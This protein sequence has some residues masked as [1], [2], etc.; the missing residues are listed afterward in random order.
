LSTGLDVRQTL[1]AIRAF[2]AGISPAPSPQEIVVDGGPGR[3]GEPAAVINVGN[4]GTGI[5]L[6]AG[7]AAALDGLTVLCGDDSIARRP[8][9][10]VA[11]PLRQMGAHVDGRQGGRFPPLTIRGGRLTGIDYSPPVASAQVKGAV[12]LAGLGAEG[13]TIVR[14]ATPTRQHT[15]E[16]LRLC[17]AD[18]EVRPGAVTVR[19]SSL[20]PFEL[21]IPG[22]P[23]QA[24]FWVVA[25]CITPGSELTVDHVYV[26][27]GRAGFLDVLRRMG[28]TVDV[29]DEQPGTLTASITA[30]YGP[31]RGTVVGGA[32]VPSLI[33]E[34]PVLAVAAAH[35]EGTT[36]FADAGEL[37]VKESDR[38]TSMVAALTAVG[39]DAEARPDGL[40]VHGRGGGPD[41]GVGGGTVDSMGDHRVAMALAIAG[42]AARSP[43]HIAGWEAVLTSYPGFEEDYR[44]C[45]SPRVS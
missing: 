30:A 11:D 33:D 38:V 16:L 18:V 9:D 1:A 28:A 32:E 13:Q 19:A 4:S 7:W 8:M 3:L 26:G 5:R 44:R 23:S 41:G 29:A 31:L 37:R 35:A 17:E 25:A 24:A 21:D 34:I 10:R 15:E 14:E 6:L 22:D 12:L 27:P 42:L 43:V 39:V 36:T 45:L 2:G 40:V 20:R